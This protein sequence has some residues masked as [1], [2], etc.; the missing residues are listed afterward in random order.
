MQISDIENHAPLGKSDHFVITFKY[1]CYHQT[2]F[3]S[4]RRQLLSNWTE[5]FMIQNQSKSVDELWSS[6]KSEIHEI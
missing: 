2:D 5:K 6:F 3:N 1:H 4:L